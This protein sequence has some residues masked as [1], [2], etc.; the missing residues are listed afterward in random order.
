MS[1]ARP[2]PRLGWLLLAAV[3]LF[4]GT[5]WVA[6]KLSLVEIPVWQYRA[7]TSEISG[8]VLLLFARLGGHPLRVPRHTWGPLLLGALFNTTAWQILIAFGVK[9]IAASEAA[10]LAYTMPIWSTILAALFLGERLTL[11]LLAA[12]ALAMAGIGVLLSPGVAQLGQSPL[13][14]ALTLG[15]ALSWALGT[16]VQKRVVWPIPVLAVAGWQLVLGGAPFVVVTLAWEPIVMQN[17]SAVALWAMV[18]T[19]ALPLLFCQYAWLKVVS[20]FPASIASIGTVLVPIV[21]VLSGA[22]VLGEAIGWREIAAL[23][24]VLASLVLVVLTPAAASAR[25]SPDR[26]H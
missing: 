19:V 2:L 24:L 8:A 22:L 5:N 7:V 25:Q 17:A 18:Y 9:L 20:L 13:G 11:R 23:L 16:F 21:G 12:L 15:A 26:G 10:I 6:L 4:W 14:V 1:A 3:S